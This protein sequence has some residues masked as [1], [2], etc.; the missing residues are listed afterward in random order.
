MD[1]TISER[2]ELSYAS[3]SDSDSCGDCDGEVSC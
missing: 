2:S 3:L 1:E